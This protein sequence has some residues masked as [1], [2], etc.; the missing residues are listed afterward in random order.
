MGQYYKAVFLSKDNKPLKKA[1]ASFFDEGP[2]LIEHAR[3]D[4]LFVMAVEQFLLNN[5]QKVVWA[6]DYAK[7]ESPETFTDADLEALSRQD[8]DIENVRK[9]GVPMYYFS[10]I[11]E[12]IPCEIFIDKSK[13][14]FLVN[15]DRKE[16]VSK[17]KMRKNEYDIQWHPL[18]LL[19][20]EGCGL[21]MGD[22]FNK[23]GAKFI[24]LWARNT[25]SAICNKA[26]IPEGYKEIK[27]NFVP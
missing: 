14:L 7:N 19:T 24:G 8:W 26:D 9:V 4:S 11:A 25:I 20:S 13:V 10:D 17:A 6:G 22:Y 12:H 2:K 3:Q 27:P 15:H 1:R 5:P 21:G 23:K 18:P 16:F